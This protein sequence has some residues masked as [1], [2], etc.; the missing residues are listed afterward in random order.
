MLE[1]EPVTRFPPNA[2]AFKI[3]VSI[4]IGMLVGFERESASKDVGIRTFGL[5]SLLGAVSVLISPAYGLV[6]MVGVIVL[7]ALLNARSLVANHSLEITTSAALLVTYALGALVGL[8]H[9]FTPVAAA[10]LMTLLLA[11]KVELRRFAGGVTMDELRSAVLLGLIGLVIYPILPDR[12]VDRWQLVNLREAWITVVVIAGIAFVNYVLLRLYGNRG[13]Y[14]TAFLG[15]L[16]NNRAAIAE[17]M[18]VVAGLRIVGVVLLA[19]LAMYLRNIAIL[20]LFAPRAL[21]TAMGPLLAMA[22]VSL[23]LLTGKRDDEPGRELA[24]TSPISL[25]RVLSYA[26]LFLA[27]QV[28]STLAERLFGNLGFI[29]ASGISGMASSAS[30]TAA[31]ANLSAGAK[32]APALAGTAVVIAS[33]A[34]TLTNLPILFKRLSRSLQ[35]K[36]VFSTTLQI[37]TGLAVLAVQRFLVFR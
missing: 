32:I 34:S 37:A 29:A 14:W 21:F 7:V 31:A 2:V 24:L 25:R 12:F 35:L 11:W 33:M 15:G 13:L 36:I 17:L 3:A 8:G 23:L 22:I 20:A 19:T 27:I 4:A 28:I 16:V 9:S 30:A 6:A 18:N 5:T 1:F 26:I 10:I